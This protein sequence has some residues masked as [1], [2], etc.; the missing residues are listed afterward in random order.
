MNYFLFLK[1]KQGDFFSLKE[2]NDLGV[3]PF[4]DFVA[5]NKDPNDI[6]KKQ[7]GFIGK[8]T[9]LWPKEARLY[10]DHY[11]LNPKA[12]LPCGMHPYSSYQNLINQGYNIGLVTGIDR[13]LAHDQALFNLLLIQK[14]IPVA[15]RLQLN[16]I[17]AP[18]LVIEEI[19]ELIDELKRF[20]SIIDIVID[21]RIIDND[22]DSLKDKV[23]KFINVYEK[24]KVDSLVIISSSSIPM[25][26]ND[27][28]KTGTS[29]YI[30]R[31][32]FV[33]WKKVQCIDSEYSSIT[34]GDYGTVSPDFQEIVSNGPIPIVPKITYT[35]EDSF[36]ISRGKI[37]T[38]HV[39]GYKQFKDIA[40]E[41]ILL[42]GFRNKFS[43]GDEY[44]ENIADNSHDKSG[45][46]TTWITATMN[47][48][49]N[50]VN[51]LI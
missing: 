43:F 46:A 34:Y 48:H 37:T 7:S 2:I 5:D 4:F 20:T 49:L 19:S 35:F 23:Q 1:S 32:E 16:D 6:L 41:V 42:K 45:N 30:K 38:Q 11:D 28:F 24:L 36:Y 13:D 31:N 25:S 21:C 18:R 39:R 12:R 40:N 14:N 17:K 9:K 27:L 47:Q 29:G 50:Y 33:L 15:I 3:V 51:Q 8:I 44:I 22:V 26:I 10:I